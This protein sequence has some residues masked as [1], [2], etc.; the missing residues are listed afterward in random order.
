M[1][2]RKVIAALGVVAALG[3]GG[4]GAASPAAG[5]AARPPAVHAVADGGGTG[6]FYHG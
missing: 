2:T 3:A 6:T 1:R 5:A 4:V